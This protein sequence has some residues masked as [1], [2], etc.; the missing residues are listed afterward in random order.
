MLGSGL[1]TRAYNQECMM[2]SF[3]I[4][5]KQCH[6]VFL[7]LVAMCSCSLKPRPPPRGK[8]NNSTSWRVEG[9]SGTILVLLLQYTLSVPPIQ[10]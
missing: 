5:E 4:V 9:G 7:L 3:G 8:A 10:P 2:T 1:E 6:H